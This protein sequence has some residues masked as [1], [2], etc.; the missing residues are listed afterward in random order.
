M[1]PVWWPGLGL[2]VIAFMVHNDSLVPLC[3]HH[4]QVKQ[5]Q[6]W[7]L[8]QPAPGVLVWLTPAGRRYTTLPSQH[9]T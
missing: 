6:G 4:H 7:T 9:P 3:R 2:S 8:T 1:V 5:A